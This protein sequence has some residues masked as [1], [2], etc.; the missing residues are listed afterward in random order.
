M[1]SV[2]NQYFAVYHWRLPITEEPEEL[3]TYDPNGPIIAETLTEQDEIIKTAVIKKMKKVQ[4]FG[5]YPSFTRCG[6]C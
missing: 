5:F 1:A 3:I 2:I 6:G 4:G